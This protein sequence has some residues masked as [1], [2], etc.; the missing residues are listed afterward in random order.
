MRFN[1]LFKR[2]EA[3][4]IIFVIVLTILSFRGFESSVHA[5]Y[6]EDTPTP[7]STPTPII[8]TL[9]VSDD[10]YVNNNTPLLNY[11]LGPLTVDGSPIDIAFLKFDLS[12]LVGYSVTSARLWL[13]VSGT[14][15]ATQTV[16]AINDDTWDACSIN[17]NNY[18]ALGSLIAT[19]PGGTS[20]TWISIVITSYV[21]SELGSI[22]SIAMDQSGT[23]GFDFFSEEDATFRP[24]LEIESF[25]IPTATSTPTI[26][27]TPTP[28]P[29]SIYGYVYNETNSLV[30]RTTAVAEGLIGGADMVL[31]GDGSGN[32]ITSSTTLSNP[33]A[34]Y[35]FSSIID[36][37]FTVTLSIPSGYVI[38]NPARFTF[39]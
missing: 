26:T 18:P 10:T 2:L 5:Q 16:K 11:C 3:F 20:G 27:N 29:F 39:W 12:S 14:S 36:G 1:R 28:T 17:Y 34:N 38:Y 6:P 30:D 4:I 31:S 22:M 24:Y 9:P 13:R 32:T 23:D 33:P 37:I 21:Q 25:I 8:Q 15:G 7:T 19:N 35:I